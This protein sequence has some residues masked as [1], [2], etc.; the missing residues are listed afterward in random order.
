MV[1]R[2]PKPISLDQ[3]RRDLVI[4]ELVRANKAIHRAWQLAAEAGDI[5]LAKDMKERNEALADQISALSGGG[6]LSIPELFA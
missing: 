1:A 5:D 3:R 2:M 6:K 4:T